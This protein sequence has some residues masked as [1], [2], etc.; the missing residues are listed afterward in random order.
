VW[1][2][3]P[4]VRLDLG[5]LAKGLAV[6]L[7]VERLRAAGIGDYLV[8]IGGETA[9]AGHDAEGER[10]RLGIADPEAPDQR[11]RGLVCDPGDG[12]CLATSGNYRQPVLIDGR[13]YYHILD[14]RS[15]NPADTAVCSVTVALPG[16]GR[17]AEADALSTAGVV[18]EAEAF[19]RLIAQRGGWCLVLIRDP[20]GSCRAFA[21]PGWAA[22]VP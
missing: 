9:V 4:G 2:R 16:H 5:G 18:L 19:G 1:R 13:E 6:D 7:A 12:L 8:Q 3:D 10:H 14:P 11:L 20:A 17:N 15:G 21:S 22:L